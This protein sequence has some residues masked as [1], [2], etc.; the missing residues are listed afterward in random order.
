MAHQK[1]RA[2]RL[3]AL[4]RRLKGTYE[5]FTDLPGEGGPTKIVLKDADGDTISGR[6]KD[7]E[8]AL[9]KLEAKVGPEPVAAEG[10]SNG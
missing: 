1:T 6:G 9:A 3:D 2:D 7:I 5:I 4:T 8:E 10:E